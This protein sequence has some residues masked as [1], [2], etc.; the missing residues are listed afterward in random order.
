MPRFYVLQVLVISQC[1][2]MLPAVFHML[3]QLSNYKL[4][5]TCCSAVYVAQVLVISQCS[6]MLPALFPI[7]S[8]PFFLL[9]GCVLRRCS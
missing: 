4:L 1:N 5:L 8:H 3:S 9:L 7:L 2:V 6:V